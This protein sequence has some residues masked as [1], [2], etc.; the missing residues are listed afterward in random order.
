M[1]RHDVDRADIQALAYTAFGPLT[2][3][4]YLMLRVADP[5]A[6]RGWLGAIKVASVDDLR[7]RCFEATQ[8][9]ITAA[10]L[11]ALGVAEPIVQRFNPE[12]VEGMAGNRNRSQRLGDTGANAPE[13]W[14]WGLGNNEPHVLLMLFSTPE[15]IADLE[16]E[17][18]EAVEQSGL[19][20]IAVLPTSDMG[21]VEP[22]GFKDGVSQPTFDWDGAR[23]PG[24]KADRTF[25]NLIALGEI[26]LGHYNEYGFPSESPKLAPDEPN[27]ALLARGGA[28]TGD[29]GRNGSYLVLRQLAQ[30]VRGFW[31]W[32]A[33]EAAR[34]GV[35]AQSLAESMVG[36]RMGGAPL[37]DFETGLA[38]PGVGPHERARNGFVFD[39]DP[40]GLSCP[41]GAHIRRANPRTGD[42]PAGVDG[43]IDNLLVTLGLTTRRLRRPTSSTLPWDKNTTV[44]PYFRHEDDAIASAR[45]H[46]ILR[47]GREYGRK[48]DREAALDPATPDPE[49][50]LHFICL[51]ANISRQF[52]F[53]QGAWLV[54]SKFASLTGEEDPLLGNRE[55]FPAPPVSAVPQPTDGFTR[56]GAEPGL[57]R[58][59]G[60]PQF[61][62]VKG[63]AYFFLPGLAA[64]RWIA[65]AEDECI[66][67]RSSDGLQ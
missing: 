30:D 21:G 24:T 47:R 42:M 39:A 40:D 17:Q 14:A 56:P 35:D 66:A 61:V 37:A 46:R 38:L 23:T 60:V 26:L 45:F 48:I 15:R 52:E 44:W 25:T 22:F 27:A 6:A 34:A 53:V 13:K 28:G 31:R 49:A 12:F 4:S 59:I 36:R 5:A 57:R 16:R 41:I 43:P 18:R 10:G 19:V 33:K 1:T 67:A 29:L 2:G 20:T 58:A 65:S 7:C 8:V 32:V 55:P 64:L 51:N 54:N 3:A 63:G 9:A 50:G 11:R 62:R